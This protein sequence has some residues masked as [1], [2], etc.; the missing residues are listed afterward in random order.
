MCYE[1]ERLYWLE[2]AARALREKQKAEETKKKEKATVPPKAD[3]P[4]SPVEDG[5]PVPV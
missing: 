4:E 2:H 3:A 1:Y 5:E